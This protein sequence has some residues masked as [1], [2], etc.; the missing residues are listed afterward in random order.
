MGG[1]WLCRHL[2][3]HH[4]FGRGDPGFLRRIYPVLAE[5][6]RFILDMLTEDGDGSLVVSPATSPEHRFYAPDGKLAA[7]TAGTS[8]DYWIADELF[9]CTLA[10]ASQLAV[11]GPLPS[12]I[13]EARGRLRRPGRAADGTL[14]EW[15][16]DLRE[17]DP[18]HRHLSHLYG[19]YPAAQAHTTARD[20]R[21]AAFRALRRRL[22]HG[23][24]STGWSLAWAIALLARFGDGEE[25]YLQLRRMTGRFLADNLLGLHPLPNGDVFQ[26]DANFGVTAAIAEMLLAS[27]RDSID[28]L[29]ALPAAWA[30]GSVTGLRTRH[31]VEVGVRWEAGGVTELALTLRDDTAHEGKTVAVTMPAMDSPLVEADTGRPAD[32]QQAGDNRV[33]LLAFLLRDRPSLF[34]G[35]VSAEAPRV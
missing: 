14:L 35:G 16:A 33:R 12:E 32:V 19:A 29:P 34:V 23:G 21:S 20:L 7:V 1:A 26:I 4:E 11:S 8:M 5:A 28:V 6:C 13:K 27:H 18:G 3:Q 22:D 30:T 31:R 24:G 17:E 2:W 9:T 10:A 25:A 15:A